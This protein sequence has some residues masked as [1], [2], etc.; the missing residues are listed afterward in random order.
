MTK[1]DWDSLTACPGWLAMR[2]YLM[3]YRNSIMNQWADGKLKG[4]LA[5]EA[6]MR[7]E[8]LSDVANMDWESID[9]FYRPPNLAQEDDGEE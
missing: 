8:I 4:P 9:K 7:C 5:D 2:G 1:E 6:A 3:D